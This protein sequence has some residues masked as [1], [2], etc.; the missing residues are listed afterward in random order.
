V[1]FIVKIRSY[2]DR[3]LATKRYV[4]MQMKTQISESNEKMPP[5]MQGGS[6]LSSSS[7]R[8]DVSTLVLG[9]SYFGTASSKGEIPIVVPTE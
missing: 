5:L 9:M 4:T 2:K 1:E 7:L 6:D 8:E 3:E